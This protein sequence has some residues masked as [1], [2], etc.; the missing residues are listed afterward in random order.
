MAKNIQAVFVDR[1]GTIGGSDSVVYPGEFTL[2]PFASESIKLL[3]NDNKMVLSFT[4]QPGIS[5]GE[6]K[7]E[8]FEKELIEFGFDKV[9]MCPHQHHEDCNC[10]KPSTGMLLQAAKEYS[11]DLEHCV[12][13]G[14]RWTDIM[15]A[16][17]VGCIK[18][19]VQTGAG[20]ESIQK[21]NNKEYYGVWAKVE[22]DYIAENLLDAVHWLLKWRGEKC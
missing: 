15:A 10:R 17:E 5:K 2:F 13:I 12:V 1:D 4:N 8:E 18:I 19:I 16:N 20:K 6:A 22:P 14:D 3:K 11:L 21:Y 7:R 9:Y